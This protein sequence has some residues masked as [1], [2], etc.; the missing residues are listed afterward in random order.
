MDLPNTLN[1]DSRE[2]LE[3]M[4]RS[5]KSLLPEVRPYTHKRRAASLPATLCQ[6]CG[7][8]LA[9]IVLFVLAI[10]IP[11]LIG[12]LVAAFFTSTE[13]TTDLSGQVL[14]WI[15]GN[16]T[17]TKVFILFGSVASGIVGGNAAL[18][19]L[20]ALARRGKNP[21]HR[22]FLVGCGC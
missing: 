7:I 15:A 18:A 20:D 22:L 11:G 16:G 9:V 17:L 3:E 6:L 14:N 8:P 13:G 4:C 10:P 1:A 12:H 5:F 21:S 2:H 19:I